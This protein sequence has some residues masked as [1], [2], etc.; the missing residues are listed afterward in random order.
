MPQTNSVDKIVQ[1]YFAAISK[2]DFTYNGVEYKAK[3]LYVSDL[4]LRGTTCPE[5]CGGCCLLFSL[6]YIPVETFPYELQPKEV[7]FNGKIV[8]VYTD[9]QL[10]APDKYCMQ[11]NQ[12]NGR[13]GIHG[14]H[15]FSC[16]FELIRI[17][18]REERNWIGTRTFGRGWAM[19]RIDGERGA[20]CE[21]LP[22]DEEG[23]FN[24]IR[25]IKR[26]KQWTDHFGLTETWIPEII[27]WSEQRRPK[28][29]LLQKPQPG[30][31][32]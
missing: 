11:L 17:V 25:K 14:V 28:S 26:L 23:K 7:K 16:D 12:E 3:P 8:T 30:A 15:P 29:M 18:T 5:N 22:P 2:E 6:D 24:A 13:C 19:P 1:S 27:E 10:K 21:T 32:F 20:L 31:L 9:L 4:L